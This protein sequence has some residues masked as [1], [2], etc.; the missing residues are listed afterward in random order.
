MQR[1][2][3]HRV[4]FSGDATRRPRVCA[5]TTVSHSVVRAFQSPTM[6]TRASVPSALTVWVTQR[7]RLPRSASSARDV[8]CT[9]M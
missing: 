3:S 9:T 4:G 2:L 8:T 7:E 5:A 1:S 6:M